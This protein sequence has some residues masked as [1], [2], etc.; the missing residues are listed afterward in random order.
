VTKKTL[1]NIPVF[2]PLVLLLGLFLTPQ[3]ETFISNAVGHP[4]IAALRYFSIPLAG[5]SLGAVIF[6]LVLKNEPRLPAYDIL[7][8]CRQDRIVYVLCIL[9]AAYSS[10]FAILRYSSL[11]TTVT[12]LGS[13]D[14]KIWAIS[15]SPNLWQS[16][17]ASAIY[18]FQPILIFYGFLYN[19]FPSVGL[20][21]ALQGVLVASASIPLYLIARDVFPQ[22]LWAICIVGIYF[23]TPAVQFNAMSAFHLDHIYIALLMWAYYYAERDRYTPVL[24]L[25]LLAVFVKEPLVLG[26][27]FFGLYLILVRGRV[28]LGATLFVGSILL[29]AAVIFLILPALDPYL[30]KVGKTTLEADFPHLTLKG[31]VFHGGIHSLKK[32]LQDI[33]I[34]QL[35]FPLFLLAPMLFLPLLNWRRFLPALPLLAIPFLSLNPLHSS[36]DSHYTA[37]IVPPLFVGLVFA[38]R[39]IAN[40]YG[41]IT[42]SALICWI[43]VMTLT[44]NIAHGPSVVSLNFWRKDWSALWHKSNYKEGPHERVLKDII[45]M[46][47]SDPKVK[48]C[49]QNNVNHSRLAH[50]WKYWAFA[51]TSHSR[52]PNKTLEADYILLDLTKPPHIDDAPNPQLY[53]EELELVK[54]NGLFTLR[55]EKDGILL[56]ENKR[57]GDRADKKY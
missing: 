30:S 10:A 43:V 3:V 54:S 49:S 34:K 33:T 19:I 11:N 15:A 22:R 46:I 57:T 47:P 38:L 2:A 20:L 18:H 1:R 29:F 28:F 27:A 37:G 31:G 24:L 7:Q 44:F 13:Y 14:Q 23:L 56:Y 16:V 5:F 4:E 8:E 50:R 55:V 21:Q 36:I 51:S 39:S 35:T 52:N 40:K 26:V 48:V 41:D 53:S 9:F 42:V 32:V 17:V 25:I 6:L 12:D 45:A